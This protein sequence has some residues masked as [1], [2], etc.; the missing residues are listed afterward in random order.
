MAIGG[1]LGGAVGYGI[2]SFG[3]GLLGGALG[4]AMSPE[5]K[6]KEAAKK[7]EETKVYSDSQ[8]NRSIGTFASVVTSFAKTVTAFAVSTRAFAISIN[9]LSEVI[10]LQS[11][12]SVVDLIA[13]KLGP[14]SNERLQRKQSTLEMVLGKTLTETDDTLSPLERFEKSITGLTSDLTNLREAET[15]RHAFNELSMRQFR[16]SLDEASK[17]L[18][19]LSG[20]TSDDDT[21]D[22]ETDGGGGG[23]GGGASSA[24]AKK[25]MDYFTSQGWTKE[26][27]A[28]IVGN[29][30]AESGANLDPTSISKNDAGPGKHSY[31]LAQ[32]NR[33]RFEKLKKF[34]DKRGTTWEDFDTQLEFIQHELTKGSEKSAGKKL[35][36]ADD[37]TEAA[38]IVDKYYERST[39]EHIGK[40]IGYAR[41]LATSDLSA[42]TDEKQFAKGS[43]GSKQ[44]ASLGK[45]LEK[46]YGVKASRHSAFDGTTPTGG[47]SANSK[48]YRDLAI[49]IN[50]PQGGV[51]EW[52]DRKWRKI[53]DRLARDVRGKGFEV[54]WGGA[55]HT[56]HLHIET[57]DRKLKAKKGGIFDGPDSGYPVELHGGEMIAP[58]STNSVL[59]KLAKTPVESEQMKQIAA[60]T[61]SV[62]KETIEKIVSMNSEMMDSMLSKLDDMVNAISDG[63][64]TRQKILKNSQ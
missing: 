1:L 30:Q 50:A 52:T 18:D 3:G 19:L 59:M 51:N 43:M 4:G 54:V 44:I 21:T 25:A 35:K 36:K 57:P 61:N 56:D 58:L 29:L 26:Q 9:K 38:K 24:N 47:H 16:Q 37:A 31:G 23:G 6:A 28:G 22:D 49:D 15:K 32:W 20:N 46:Q 60:P 10:K 64:E 14:Q 45:S 11:K 39:G 33:D 34:A 53:F 12:T 17:K 7:K 40:R 48:H 5:E 41:D 8:F 2:G 63:N 13:Q 62:E 42:M 55:G 27:A